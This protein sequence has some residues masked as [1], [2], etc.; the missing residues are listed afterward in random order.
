MCD[1]RELRGLFCPR[2]ARFTLGAWSNESIPY[3]KFDLTGVVLNTTNI[4]ALL[5]LQTSW[6]DTSFPYGYFTAAYFHDD[7][8]DEMNITY[9]NAPQPTTPHTNSVR[10]DNDWTWYSW[11]VTGLVLSA[12]DTDKRLSIAILCAG[13]GSQ[14][15]FFSSSERSDT[16]YITLV[17]CPVVEWTPL[18]T[19][20]LLCTW[21]L[22]RKQ[23]VSKM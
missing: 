12:M 8:W 14:K 18:W 21:G 4:T 10:V 7:S 2:S 22:T 1:Q 11:N 15:A 19:G 3:L 16:P 17:S 23:K 6:V 13:D 5:Y 20:L 9:D